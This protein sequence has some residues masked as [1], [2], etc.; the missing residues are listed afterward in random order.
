MRVQ[1]VMCSIFST[2][3]TACMST[4]WAGGAVMMTFCATGNEY[5]CSMRTMVGAAKAVWEV[6]GVCAG[7]GV[8]AVPFDP[9]L[10]LVFVT[11]PGVGKTFLCEK[12]MQ[13]LDR[14]VFEVV[15]CHGDAMATGPSHSK[16]RH[17]WPAV[18]KAA[19]TRRADGRSTIVLADK[20]LIDSP[21]GGL[22]LCVCP[23]VYS[24]RMCDL[25]TPVPHHTTATS[26]RTLSWNS[27]SHVAVMASKAH[28]TGDKDVFVLCMVT[29]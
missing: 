27:I 5:V 17:F 8:E 28:S 1:T 14:S 7:Q 26:L 18:A 4:R 15:H 3:T 29:A 22:P 16:P 24:P 23:S 20:N 10:V 13:S 9:A 12:L 19:A 25:C 21:T 11:I 6:W 2:I